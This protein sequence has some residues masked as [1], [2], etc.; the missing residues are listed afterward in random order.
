MRVGA[1][2]S[3]YIPW[4]GYFDFID[5]VDLFIFHDDVQYTKGDWRNR[6][7]IKTSTGLAWVTVPVHYRHTSQLILETEICYDHDWI[8]EHIG[9]ITANYRRAPHFSIVKEGFFPLLKQRFRTITELNVAT[10]RWIM[11]VLSIRTPLKMSHELGLQGAKT[12][13][14]IQML[15]KVGGTE[16][17]SGPAARQYIDEAAFREANIS[18]EYKSYDYGPYPQLGDGFEVAVTVLDLIANT[19]PEA[20]SHLRS[21]TPNE[22][23][24]PRVAIPHT[25]KTDAA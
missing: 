17:V 6:N 21:R 2:Q 11:D 16:Y 1:I 18:L 23:V 24:V 8:N 9:I 12:S 22:L 14:L 25:P 3:N 10:C 5:S 13:R 4:V 7:K 15:K 19:G 20:R